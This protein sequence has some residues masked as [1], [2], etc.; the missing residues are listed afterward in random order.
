MNGPRAKCFL[1]SKNESGPRVRD[2]IEVSSGLPQTFSYLALTHAADALGFSLYEHGEP[3]G[4]S[5]NDTS[6][7]AYTAQVAAIRRLPP[8]ERLRIGIDLS[9]ATRR[10]ALDGIRRRQPGIGDDDAR[11]ELARMLYGSDLADR[12]WKRAR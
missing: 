5:M 1:L 4:V 7:A 2:G 10:I 8:E 11:Y 3:L 9:Q 12:A 6:D